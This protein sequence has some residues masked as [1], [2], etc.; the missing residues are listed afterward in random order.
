MRPG[1]F[2]GKDPSV[3][4]S[5]DGFLFVASEPDRFERV[6]AAARL[7]PPPPDR[8]RALSVARGKLTYYFDAVLP[9]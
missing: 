7:A 9:R 6:L 8:H 1:L 3:D 5:K 2:D 4:P